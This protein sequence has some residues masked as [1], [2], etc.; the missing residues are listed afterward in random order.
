M[1]MAAEKRDYYEILGITKS[2]SADEIKKA[3]RKM[4][5]KYH[6]D[7]NPGSKEAEE[8]FKE[9]AEA[10]AVL[11]DAEKK[12]LYDQ[13]GHSLGGRGFSGFEGFEGAF[14][15]FS[16]I[17]G[18]LFSDFF[19]TS[20]R[21]SRSE[22]ARRGADLQYNIEV[23]LEDSAKGREVTLTIP[24][25]ETCDHCSGS[26]AEP[27]SKRLTCPECRG[28][29]QVRVSQGFFMFQRTCP[30][31]HGEGERIEKVCRACRGSGRVEKT[32]TLNVKIPAGIES[33]SR[34]KIGGE[35]EAGRRGG[36]HGNLYVLVT[37]KEH[38]HFE[39]EG[40]DLLS[41]AEIPFSIACLGGEVE[42]PALDGKV[43]LKIPAG[44]PNG[45]IFRLASKGFPSLH[46]Y[47]HGDELVRVKV[48]V[49]SRLSE[50]EKKALEEFARLRGEEVSGL[51][52]F[53]ERV[54]ENLK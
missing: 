52:N 7:R 3:Y 32:R 27:G 36:G 53:F 19:G 23:T 4:A 28:A 20:A 49:P 31:C 43:K 25:Q 10:Y 13:F 5:L 15:D 42:V 1:K 45:K 37:V 44:T 54:K 16:D 26:G 17:F 14:S 39:R 46:G 24:R 51:K 11:S 41:E 40:N 18:D 12:S 35:G 29:G 22:K 30:S 50:K 2:A 33:G 47:G 21:S 6:P 38:P 9:A 8:K 48:H 34:L